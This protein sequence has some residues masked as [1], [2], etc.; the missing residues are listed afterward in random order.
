MIAMELPI[1][2]WCAC[3]SALCDEVCSRLG[4]SGS[5]LLMGLLLLTSVGG[6]GLWPRGL[7]L[8]SKKV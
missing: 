3:Q 2:A 7:D 5:V 1:D 6:V 8:M 4:W